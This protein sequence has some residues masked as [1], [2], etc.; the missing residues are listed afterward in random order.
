[1]YPQAQGFDVTPGFPL[2]LPAD[3]SEPVLH[4]DTM[5]KILFM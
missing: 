5:S 3:V 1:M 2:F 4:A